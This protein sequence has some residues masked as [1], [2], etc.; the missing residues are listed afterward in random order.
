M[1]N[2]DQPSQSLELQSVNP[3]SRW[4]LLCYFIYPLGIE[5]DMPSDLL[6]RR[7]RILV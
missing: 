5:R 4:Q 3:S 2:R 1:Q 6:D 7:E